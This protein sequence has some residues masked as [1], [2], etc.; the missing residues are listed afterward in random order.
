MSEQPYAAPSIRTVGTLH[1][2]TLVSPNKY[3]TKTPDGVTF[4]PISGPPVS[5]T[6]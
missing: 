6:S 4:H 1:D 2:L 3:V 5:L